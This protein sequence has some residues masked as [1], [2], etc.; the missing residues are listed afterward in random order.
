MTWHTALIAYH[1]S[2]RQL[3]GNARD[4]L[5][6]CYSSNGQNA[7][8]GTIQ[9]SWL[10]QLSK[11]RPLNNASFMSPDVSFWA[12]PPMSTVPSPLLVA[13]AARKVSEIIVSQSSFCSARTVATLPSLW[14]LS[15]SDIDQP[16]SLC[17]IPTGAES[18]SFPSISSVRRFS[19]RGCFVSDIRTRA[20]RVRRACAS[21][22]VHASSSRR[23][24]ELKTLA[25]IFRICLPV[26]LS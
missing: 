9:I 21:N 1:H 16:V 25:D 19:G 14:L 12:V 22:A 23:S 4:Q 2:K 24:Q 6:R 3:K 20:L 17:D 5:R 15:Q 10:R 18:L 13:L 7:Y 11:S 26:R 8:E